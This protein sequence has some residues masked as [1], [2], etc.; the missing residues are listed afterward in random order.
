[1][2]LAANYFTLSSTSFTTF[3]SSLGGKHSLLRVGSLSLG[4]DGGGVGE[5]RGAWRVEK[6]GNIQHTTEI[7]VSC[8]ILPSPS[9]EAEPCSL[10]PLRRMSCTLGLLIERLRGIFVCFGFFLEKN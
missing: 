1:M 8:V 2:V 4:M 10:S 7:R 5:L 3:S 6:G 9:F